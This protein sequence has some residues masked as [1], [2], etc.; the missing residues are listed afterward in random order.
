MASGVG[1]L[2]EVVGNAGVLVDP[3]SVESIAKGI[4]EVLLADKSKYNGYVEAGL[5][6]VK[7]FSWERSARETLKII[8][9]IK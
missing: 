7:K 4:K 9:N 2:P 3:K 6:Q 5:A 8:T 1:S